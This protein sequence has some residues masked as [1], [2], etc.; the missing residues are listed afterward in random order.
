MRVAHGDGTRFV[1][2]IVAGRDT[3][4]VMDRWLSA[5]AN[6]NHRPWQRARIDLGPWSGRTV[7]LRLLTVSGPDASGIF[8]ASRQTRDDD[9][10][11]T[12]PR[13]I[14]AR[15][16]RPNV[17]VILID[18]LRRDALGSYGGGPSPNLDSLAAG[19]V[20]FDRAWATGSWTHPSTA[21]LL[22]GW[23][24]SAHGLGYGPPG[25]TRLAAAAP[26]IA[27][28]FRAA[29][30]NTAAASNNKIVSVEDGFGRGF[31]AFDERAFVADQFHGAERMTRAAIEWLDTNPDGPFFLYLHYFDPHDRYQAPRPFTRRHIGRA[32][33]EKVRD[34]SVRAGRPN[35]FIETM[36]PDARDLTPDEVRYL[37]GLYRGE[38]SYV[39]HWIGRLLG[40]L[41]E[42]G[43]LDDTIV[44]VTS[45]HGEEFLEHEG[46]KH[47]H[48][49]Y[50]ELV[51]VP[52]LLRLPGD[53]HAGAVRAE[54]VSLV[55][56]PAT[57]RAVAGLPARDGDRAWAVDGPPS[58]RV[59]VA[60]N[61]WDEAG[62]RHGLQQSL[63]RWPHKL[64]R[65]GDGTTELFDLDRDP[66]EQRP[67]DDDALRERMVVSLD[68]LL[69]ES[70]GT[71]EAGPVD[72]ALLEKLKAMGYVH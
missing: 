51:A 29:G 45:D 61:W 11:F 38:V 43:R 62:P 50:D 47:A 44:L 40:H 18:T 24:P 34:T 32:L 66:A 19:G 72:P 70:G 56:L 63:V 60:E 27:E 3:T 5:F 64:V 65:Y 33:E 20:R 6:P 25:T 2:Q 69:D 41:E 59:V 13:L 12:F 46:L 4:V 8:P 21:S 71:A 17:L 35:P 30:W 37:K 42:S 15:D 1:A 16:E 48:T 31:A 52:L 10:L 53:R 26:M 7:A 9:P 49:L 67:L 54:P 55:D 28:D 23:L 68:S 14:D 36:N 22:T 39:D 58:P 57:L